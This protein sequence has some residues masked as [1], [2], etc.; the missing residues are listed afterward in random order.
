V[1]KL[2]AG[3]TDSQTEGE[4]NGAQEYLYNT[5]NYDFS[6]QSDLYLPA[7]HTL[8][9]GYDFRRSEAENKGNYSVNHRTQNAL[10]I[11]DT[12]A[13]NEVL[14][15]NLGGRYDDFSDV[16]GRG[17]WKAAYS[18]LP[19]SFIRLHGSAGTAYKAPTMNDLYWPTVVYPPEWGGGGTGGNPD[20]QSERSLAYDTGL[21]LAFMDRKI[22]TDAT[23]FYNEIK[24]LIEWA[25]DNTGFWSPRN[26]SAATTKGVETFL[27][28]APLE[29]FSTRAH[30]TYTDAKS[31]ETKRE[32]A[33]RAKHTAGLLFQLELLQYLSFHT[34]IV[35]VGE[36]FDNA[37]NTR[38]MDDYTLVHFNLTAHLTDQWDVILNIDN[39]FDKEYENAAGYGTVGRVVSLGTSLTF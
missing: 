30:Y 12:I 10:F 39:A 35:Y 13:I 33:R 24:N 37:T 26:V 1:Q 22:V 7:N 27:E 16:D 25:P 38:K 2:I 15:F 6:A 9:I 14:F 11:H 32:L 29:W 19:A 3:Y 5:K 20:L 8:S 31:D 34:D 23:L 21:E 36:R 17:T 18:C 4:A 28:L